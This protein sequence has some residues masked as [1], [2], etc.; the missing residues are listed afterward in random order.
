[1]P[2]AAGNAHPNTVKSS[3]SR[4]TASPVGLGLSLESFTRLKRRKTEKASLLEYHRCNTDCSAACNPMSGRLFPLVLLFPFVLMNKWDGG[5]ISISSMTLSPSS[6][7]PPPV[8]KTFLLS[9]PRAADRGRCIHAASF[10]SRLLPLRV[11]PS[12]AHPADSKQNVRLAMSS[13]LF[14]FVCHLWSPG[15]AMQVT[16]S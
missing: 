1:M 12:L 5:S 9:V 2:S 16:R 7:W 6:V 11:S 4:R 13:N 10:N 3:K 14:L 8:L 15:L